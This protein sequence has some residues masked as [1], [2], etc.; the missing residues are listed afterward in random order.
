MKQIKILFIICIF[1]IISC[2]SYDNGNKEEESI[3]QEEKEYLIQRTK[4][5][6]PQQLP[7]VFAVGYASGGYNPSCPFDT[8]ITGFSGILIGR[9]TMRNN[10]GTEHYTANI[11]F[12][13]FSL[14]NSLFFDGK[15]NITHSINWSLPVPNNGTI[16]YLI[17]NI[18]G[19]LN[20]SGSLSC[21]LVFDKVGISTTYN[22]FTG[23]HSK[24]ISGKLEIKKGNFSINVANLFEEL[25]IQYMWKKC[26]Q[27]NHDVNPQF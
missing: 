11:E 2:C 25:I 22:M 27:E 24:P 7:I 20:L 3:T 23:V 5:L 8:A 13:N 17:K 6:F 10:N 4:E 9:T 15:L 21:K 18:S 19:I 26:W 14:D 1:F 12:K 16:C